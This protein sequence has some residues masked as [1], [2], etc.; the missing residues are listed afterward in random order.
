MKVCA[1]PPNE[2]SS[3]NDGVSAPRANWAVNFSELVR[4]TGWETETVPGMR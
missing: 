3:A 1:G 4:A 2:V